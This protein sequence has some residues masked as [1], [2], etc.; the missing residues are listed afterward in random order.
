MMSKG[1]DDYQPQIYTKVAANGKNRKDLK[2]SLID[3]QD[4][5]LAAREEI[6][7]AVLNLKNIKFDEETRINQSK[8]LFGNLAYKR[9]KEF[10]F[11]TTTAA[12]EYIRYAYERDRL[13]DPDYKKAAK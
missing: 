2:K 9:V 7:T 8:H 12:M 10:E 4:K 13:K 6:Q 3:Q 1:F 5:K 11:P